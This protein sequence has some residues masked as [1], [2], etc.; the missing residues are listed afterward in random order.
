MT[1][2]QTSPTASSHEIQVK[3]RRTVES[4]FGFSTSQNFPLSMMMP[5]V[6]DPDILSHSPAEAMTMSAPRSIGR[7]KN[8]PAPAV[9]VTNFL[10][11]QKAYITVSKA[12]TTRGTP[13]LWAAL[14]RSLNIRH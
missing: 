11:S 2:S 4:G 3:V 6:F 13:A 14:A 1:D 9:F 7:I 12:Y 10:V 8:P 5:A